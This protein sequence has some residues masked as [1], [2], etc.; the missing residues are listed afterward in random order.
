MG[1][2]E[3]GDALHDDVAACSCTIFSCSATPSDKHGTYYILF[4]L[5]TSGAHTELGTEN[6]KRK[7]S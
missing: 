1:R 2:R 5:Q 3:D 7:K 6:K 4:R